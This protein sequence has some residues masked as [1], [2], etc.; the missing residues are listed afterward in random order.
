MALPSKEDLIDRLDLE[1][2]PEGGFYKETWR[3]ERTL[4]A[5]ALEG[6]PGDRRAAT[7]IVFLLP[8]GEES[9]PHRLSS[10][11]LWI[12]QGGD[13]LALTIRESLDEEGTTTVLGPDDELQAAVPPDHWQHARALEGPA[14]YALVACVVAPGFEFEDFVLIDEDEQETSEDGES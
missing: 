1:P 14:G 5:E 13:R 8:T 12:H 6:Y 10:E 3:A 11:E 9:R 4:P 2:H 7:S